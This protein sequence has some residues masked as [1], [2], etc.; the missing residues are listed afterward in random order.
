[1]KKSYFWE[2]VIMAVEIEEETGARYWRTMKHHEMHDF[3]NNLSEGRYL[4]DIDFSTHQEDEAI[5]KIIDTALDLF[6]KGNQFKSLDDAID[7]LLDDEKPRRVWT[8]EEIKTLIQNNDKALY[9]ALL[10]LYS[11][12]TDDEKVM[13]CAHHFNGAGF[14]GVDA[15]ILSSFAEFLKKTGFLTPKQRF[16]ARKKLIKYNKQLTRLANVPA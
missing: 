1:M 14:N 9:K 10:K 3:I 2:N 11:L 8:E 7:S 4:S 15:P 6:I 5:G 13:Q 16:I 12:Q